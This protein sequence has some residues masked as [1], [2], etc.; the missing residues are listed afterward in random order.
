MAGEG[1]GLCTGQPYL[2]RVKA[3]SGVGG[4]CIDRGPA[5]ALG[6][7]GDGGLVKSISA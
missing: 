4:Q 6:S 5:G 7:C 2:G 1:V 3:E